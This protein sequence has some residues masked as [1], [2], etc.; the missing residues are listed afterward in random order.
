MTLLTSAILMY[1]RAGSKNWP[2]ASQE[3]LWNWVT[4]QLPKILGQ[5]VKSN[6]LSVWT[7]FLEYILGNRDPRRAQP[8]VDYIIQETRIMEYNQELSLDGTIF[9]SAIDTC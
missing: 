8:V 9:F 5:N 3:T 2:L 6:T 1:T 7:S 4:P